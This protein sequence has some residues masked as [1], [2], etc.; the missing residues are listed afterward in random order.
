MSAHCSNRRIPYS[1]HCTSANGE[2]R[3]RVGG[4]QMNRAIGKNN[5]CRGSLSLSGEIRGRQCE[6]QAKRL[7]DIP[8]QPITGIFYIALFHEGR[9]EQE[10][11]HL[12]RIQARML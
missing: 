6:R 9:A 5:V 12:F 8:F 11:C 7:A 1:D 4:I 10:T 2:C 3:R